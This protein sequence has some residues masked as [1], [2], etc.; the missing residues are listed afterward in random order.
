MKIYDYYC[1]NCGHKVAGKKVVFDLAQILDLP[2]VKSVFGADAII[3]LAPDD[4]YELAKR[5]GVQLASGRKVKIE[6]TLSELLNYVGQDIK[7]FQDREDLVSMTYDE[8]TT[9]VQ[10]VS[11][12]LSNEDA[13]QTNEV[14]AESVQKLIDEI[15]SKLTLK[16]NRDGEDEDAWVQDIHNYVVC[17]WM[18]PVFFTGTDSLDTLHYSTEEN[19]NNLLPFTF[20]QQEIRGYCPECGQPILAGSGRYEQFLIGFLGAQSAG[21]TTLFVSMINHLYQSPWKMEEMGIKF[22]T[23]LCDGRYVKVRKAI[24]DNRKGWAVGKTDA[25]ASAESFNASLMITK[26]ERK[27]I[28]TF[29]DIAGE[30][31]YDAQKKGVNLEALQRFPLITACHMY[32]LCTCVSQRGYGEADEESAAIDN[33]A[34]LKIAE[35]IYRHRKNRLSIPPM[36][37][38]VTKVDMAKAQGGVQHTENPFEGIGVKR[39]KNQWEKGHAF[40]LK[41]E[42]DTLKTLYNKT[43]NQDVLES[44][45][46]C[47]YTYKNNSEM[48]YLSMLSCSALGKPGRKYDPEK[49]DYDTDGDRFTPIRLE[50]VWDWI[51][52]NL[53]LLPVVDGYCFSHI[54][55]YGESYYLEGDFADYEIRNDY[56]AEEEAKR[57]KGIYQMF[58]NPSVHDQE[59]HRFHLE[60]DDMSPLK[61]KFLN[62][63]GKR[64][65]IIKVYLNGFLRERKER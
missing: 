50:A 5:N 52:R 30:L 26:G 60:Y 8:F 43:D 25:Y 37:L 44:L 19:P 38:V 54:P 31:C 17:F 12:L 2:S 23:L 57:T 51:L 41:D 59:L 7:K 62:I 36:C 27:V 22:P 9:N 48:T 15:T 16:E 49:Y 55:S 46:W 18:E 61:K 65:E 4:V 58:L 64:Q 40:H 33:T 3:R 24:D 42:I 20:E 63:E 14:N 1:T 53:G 56:T 13:G 35:E 21:K 29:V 34:L 28:L 10:A 47:C 45:G 11:N 6:L 32:M 39:S